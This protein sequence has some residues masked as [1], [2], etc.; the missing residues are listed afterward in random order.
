MWLEIW[1][2]VLMNK[3][4]E[5]KISL[6]IWL[7]R[8][9]MILRMKIERI[10]NDWNFLF[11]FRQSKIQWGS[12]PSKMFAFLFFLFLSQ[13]NVGW[14]DRLGRRLV[15]FPGELRKQILLLATRQI[16]KLVGNI[17][18]LPLWLFDCQL[19]AHVVPTFPLQPQLL[20]TSLTYFHCREGGSE[21]RK[22]MF[23]IFILVSFSRLESHT[24]HF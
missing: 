7:N 17:R 14:K 15:Q 5:T 21:K 22:F 23:L 9:G 24:R 10:L 19:L 18:L 2:K 6:K 12:R 3:R 20:P 16:A 13:E 8:V 1:E 11:P 4:I